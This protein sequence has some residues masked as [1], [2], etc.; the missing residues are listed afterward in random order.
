MMAILYQIIETQ[1]FGEDA[2]NDGIVDEFDFDGDG[3][4]NHLD[5]DS[6]NDGIFDIFEVGNYAN[7]TD[8]DGNNDGKPIISLVITD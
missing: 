4:P 1:I 2:N 7:D 8:S 5:L 6:D 3:V